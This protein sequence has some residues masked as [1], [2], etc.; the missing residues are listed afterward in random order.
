MWNQSVSLVRKAFLPLE[1]FEK[2]HRTLKLMDAVRTIS[3]DTWKESIV[4]YRWLKKNGYPEDAKYA[5]N[6]LPGIVFGGHC[7]KR[8]RGADMESMTGLILLDLDGLKDFD[9][10]I[11]YENISKQLRDD[12]NV[13]FWF[14]SPTNGLK[15]AVLTDLVEVGHICFK[16]GYKIVSEELKHKYALEDVD[17]ST[18]DPARVCYVSY[19]PEVLNTVKVSPTPY[20]V[21]SKAQL[22]SADME[23]KRKEKYERMMLKMSSHEIDPE[24]QQRNREWLRENVGSSI[25][26]DNRYTAMFSYGV[27]L[28]E[29]GLGLDEIVTELE[30]T[31]YG[32]KDPQSRA[33]CA[34]DFWVE[35]GSPISEF[36]M[37]KKKA[38]IR[39][40]TKEN[41]KNNFTN[42]KRMIK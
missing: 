5:K 31:D 28:A 16:V 39:K 14:R 7:P 26:E 27:R 11:K 15:I 37:S 6:N 33:E 40:I 10:P 32:D 21:K 18:C 24:K 30:L 3:N 1:E 12:E 17:P 34:V 2:N 36:V 22:M 25:C 42:L 20:K 9:D 29:I 13:V 4:N 8:R 35:E 19:D 23:R 38:D 41:F